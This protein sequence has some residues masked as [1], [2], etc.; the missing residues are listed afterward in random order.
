MPIYCSSKITAAD[1]IGAGD[2][3]GEG[4][5]SAFQHTSIADDSVI[6]IANGGSNG[7]MLLKVVD[8]NGTNR[9]SAVA[10]FSY[11][12]EAPSTICDIG[13]FS[14]HGGSSSGG[15]ARASHEI[16][17]WVGNNYQDEPGH[18]NNPVSGFADSKITIWTNYPKGLYFINRTGFQLNNLDCWNFHEKV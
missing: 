3:Y 5:G 1:N 11:M 18:A 14:G 12:T 7:V 4:Y 15:T 17:Y 2:T 8:F 6:K 13:H 10:M 16:K 9:V